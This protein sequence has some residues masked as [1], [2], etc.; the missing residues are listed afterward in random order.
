M[1]SI[2]KKGENWYCQFRF[3]RRRHTFTVGRVDESEA[4]AIRARVDYVLMRLKQGLMDLPAG[5][6]VVA[7]V[8]HDGRLPAAKADPPPDTTFR[9]FR[10]AYLKT[11]G[12]GSIEANSLDT[13]GIHLSHFAQT[14][15]EQFPMG[16]LALADL[17][18]H[19]DRRRKDV[20]GVTIKKEID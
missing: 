14:F 6:D 4:E 18:R 13:V 5:S 7:F 20:A 17:Q 15:G 2:Q 19:I 11:V 10:D 8:Q 1:A 3:S 9:K 12:Q 16:G